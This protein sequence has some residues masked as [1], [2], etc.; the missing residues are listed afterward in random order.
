[1]RYSIRSMIAVVIV[2]MTVISYVRLLTH[3]E[4]LKLLVIV[5]AVSG[6]IVGLIVGGWRGALI[7]CWIGFVSGLLAP[8]I[9][10]P[11]WVIFDLPPVP[12]EKAFN[13]L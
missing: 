7:G 9:Y 3:G 2:A 13:Y 10:G 1:M 8:V 11:F 12:D 6:S 4:P 5:G